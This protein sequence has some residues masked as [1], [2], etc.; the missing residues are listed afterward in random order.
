GAT[1]GERPTMRGLRRRS[2]LWRRSAAGVAIGAL[3]AS[4]TT[5]VTAPFVAPVFGDVGPL[6]ATPLDA[7]VFAGG[8][9]GDFTNDC[10]T[11]NGL[12][13]GGVQNGSAGFSINDVTTTAASDAFDCGAMVWVGTTAVADDDGTVDVSASGGDQVLTVSTQAVGG[14]QVTDTYRMF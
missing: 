8:T 7:Q 14:L 4:V 9:E 2:P 3:L 11:D 5:V 1:G 10:G 12:P 13:T 6:A